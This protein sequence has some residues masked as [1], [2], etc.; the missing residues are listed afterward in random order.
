[1]KTELHGG[2]T[3]HQKTGLRTTKDGPCFPEEDSGVC[4]IDQL[5]CPETHREMRQDGRWAPWERRSRTFPERRQELTTRPE[6]QGTLN[7]IFFL[8][9]PHQALEPAWGTLGGQREASRKALTLLWNGQRGPWET[10]IRKQIPGLTEQPAT[11]KTQDTGTSQ[12]WELYFTL[13]C[14]KIS[15][16]SNLRVVWLS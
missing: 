6:A 3:D 12:L 11:P 7:S 8:L 1:M 16:Q 9:L 13:A 5:Y 14:R 2:L 15:C 4:G 10:M